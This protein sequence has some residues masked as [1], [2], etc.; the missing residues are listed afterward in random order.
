MVKTVFKAMTVEGR[1]PK[2]LEEFG[3]DVVEE[4]K[5]LIMRRC[6]PKIHGYEGFKVSCTGNITL[7]A[8]AAWYKD[9]SLSFTDSQSVA[10]TGRAV[11]G[12]LWRA[13]Y[14]LEFKYAIEKAQAKSKAHLLRRAYQLTHDDVAEAIRVHVSRQLGDALNT[15][16][17]PGRKPKEPK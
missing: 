1:S 6:G 14:V 17:R 12:P 16:F 11:R 2:N 8:G 10:V 3:S 15:Q 5:A 7:A 4:L 13:Q 9:Q